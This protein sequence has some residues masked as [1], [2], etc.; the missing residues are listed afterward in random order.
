MFFMYHTYIYIYIHI[1]IH[2]YI[3]ISRNAIMFSLSFVIVIQSTENT[4]FLLFTSYMYEDTNWWHI[5]IY[6]WMVSIR[7]YVCSLISEMKYTTIHI[8]INRIKFFHVIHVNMYWL[9]CCTCSI[10]YI[11]LVIHITPGGV[12]IYSRGEMLSLSFRIWSCHESPFCYYYIS[13]YIFFR[14]VFFK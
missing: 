10:E 2:T 9:T 13:S 4:C 1:Y 12:A 11:W 8:L 14:E 3:Y 6:V 7:Q 5:Y